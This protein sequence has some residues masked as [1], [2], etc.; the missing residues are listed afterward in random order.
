MRAID[1]TKEYAHGIGHMESRDGRILVSFYG[2]RVTQAWADDRATARKAL[3]QL[4][5]AARAA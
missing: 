2:R 4:A 3:S 5:R 1:Y